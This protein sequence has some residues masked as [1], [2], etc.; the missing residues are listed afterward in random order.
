MIKKSP[1]L[2]FSIFSETMN[3]VVTSNEAIS[4]TVE[5]NAVGIGSVAGN[6]TELAA[7]MKEIFHSQKQVQSVIEDLAKQA[8]MFRI[9]E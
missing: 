9:S 6:T 5:Q 3:E 7:N 1:R 2:L 4:G 8:E